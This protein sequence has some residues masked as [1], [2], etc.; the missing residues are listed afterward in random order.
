MIKCQSNLKY[1]QL[2][3]LL[4]CYYKLNYKVVSF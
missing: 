3:Q 4:T 2:D 1:K